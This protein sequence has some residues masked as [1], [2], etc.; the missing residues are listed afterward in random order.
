ML[1]Y[2]CI[3]GSS[4]LSVIFIF[5]SAISFFLTTLGIFFVGIFISIHCNLAN[6]R[7]ER[8]I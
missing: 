8:I 4:P 2:F 1:L 7:I 5:K 3:P 6:E